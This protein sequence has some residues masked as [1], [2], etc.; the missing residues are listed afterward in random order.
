VGGGCEVIKRSGEFNVVLGEGGRTDLDG[1]VG[2]CGR[3]G[4]GVKGQ[5]RSRQNYGA[6]EL[7][8]WWQNSS[9]SD[10]GYC[11]NSSLCKM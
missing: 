4:S 8:G 7:G 1:T 10:A 11:F 3:G 9:S 6:K 5:E 2:L